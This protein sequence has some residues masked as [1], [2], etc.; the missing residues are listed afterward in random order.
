MEID[1]DGGEE[2]QK[3]CNTL[4]KR[5]PYL[6]G[7]RRCCSAAQSDD[8]STSNDESSSSSSK[9]P[10]AGSFVDRDSNAATNIALKLLVHTPNLVRGT[11]LKQPWSIFWLNHQIYSKKE[12]EYKIKK[13]P[14][15][16]L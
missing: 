4:K 8:D 6:R 3:K 9:C 15:R 2:E 11:R 12:K 7:L 13:P 10:I 5:N 16:A 14:H 1:S